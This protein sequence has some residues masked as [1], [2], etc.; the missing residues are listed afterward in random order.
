ME[1]R[2]EFIKQP[3]SAYYNRDIPGEDTFLTHVGPGT[4]GGEYLRR[5]WHPIA[6]SRELKDL[7]VRKRILGEDLVV[8]RDGRGEVGMLELHCCHRGTSLEYGRIEEHGIRCCYHGWQF[9]VDGRILDTPLEP[10]GST[11]KDRFYHGAYI[12]REHHEVVWGYMGPPDRIPDLPALDLMAIPGS[13]LEPGELSGGPNHKPC[14]W[15]QVVDNFVDPQHEEYLHAEHSGN[16]FISRKGEIVREVEMFGAAEYIETPT[17]ILTLEMRRVNDETVW[18]RNIEYKWPNIAVLGALNEWPPKF[19]DGEGEL[20]N[21]PITMDWAVPMDD[22]NTMEMSLV[23]TP[24]GAENP[25]TKHNSPALQSNEPGRSYEDMQRT[26]GD[27]EAQIG[28]RPIAIHAREHLGTSDRGVAMMRKGLREGI[29]EVQQGRDPHGVY[30]HGKIVP[31]YGGDTA[32]RLKPAKSEAEDEKL[33]REAGRDLAARY[34]KSPPNCYDL[35]GDPAIALG[36]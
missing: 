29:E 13:T 11:L 35:D 26:P 28:Q 36:G 7:P 25:R 30:R 15:L 18:V 32:L 20:H 2:A 5:F 33:I 12:V 24:I 19:T 27:Y 9:D 31:T 10:A 21:Y 14:S 16:Q 22:T 17:G 6:Y 23:V 34:F 4:P 3:F 8:F 1:T